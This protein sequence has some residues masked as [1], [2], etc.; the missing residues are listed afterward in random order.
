MSLSSPTPALPWGKWSYLVQLHGGVSNWCLPMGAPVFLFYPYFIPT[1][2]T[3]FTV[4]SDFEVFFSKMCPK[5]TK[6]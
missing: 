2:V 1:E 4:L 3:Y 6:K 5:A